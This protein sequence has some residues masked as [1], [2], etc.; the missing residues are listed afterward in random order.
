MIRPDPLR[1]PASCDESDLDALLQ[2]PAWLQIRLRVTLMLERERDRCERGNAEA[3][4]RTAQGAV[5]A[6]RT[7]L[8]LPEIIR[9][10]LKKG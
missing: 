5:A 1:L 6:L 10:E 7:V 4:I 2:N 3:E 9:G 8:K